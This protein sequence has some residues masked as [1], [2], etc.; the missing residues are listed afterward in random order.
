MKMIFAYKMRT[1]KKKKKK[2]ERKEIIEVKY[3]LLS[4]LAIV[5]FFLSGEILE[6]C[7]SIYITETHLQ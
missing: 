5:V 2:I 3:E 1:S 6:Y 4:M 7:L